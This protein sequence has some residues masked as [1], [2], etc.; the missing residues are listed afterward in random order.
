MEKISTWEAVWN[1]TVDEI[2]INNI[3]WFVSTIN[4][5]SEDLLFEG[6]VLCS[7]GCQYISNKS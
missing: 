4:L 7:Y 2:A 3:W 6:F 5:V 1:Q